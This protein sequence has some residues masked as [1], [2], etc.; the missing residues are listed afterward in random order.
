MSDAYAGDTPKDPREQELI[1][2]A[3]QHPNKLIVP[4]AHPTRFPGTWV[5]IFK[6]SVPRDQMNALEMEGFGWY[7]KITA[8]PNGKLQVI[9]REQDHPDRDGDIVHA[10]TQERYKQ[11]THPKR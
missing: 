8:L 7:K 3:R 5:A 10:E 6:D 9:I 1:W 2:P 11:Y 4:E